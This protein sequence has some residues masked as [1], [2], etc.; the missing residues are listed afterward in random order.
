MN[1]P[2]RPAPSHGKLPLRGLLRRP[3]LL[4]LFAGVA[5][6]PFC[7]DWVWDLDTAGRWSVEAQLDAYYSS[8]GF[9]GPLSSSPPPELDLGVSGEKNIYGFLA[10]NF[11]V[12][13]FWLLEGSVNPMP[14][15]GLYLKSQQRPFYDASDVIH[16]L[17]LVQATTA[18]FPEPGAA[19]FFLG[20]V[21]K[22]TSAGQTVGRGYSG[23]VVSWA[24]WHILDN[25][26]IP[27]HW[28]E[29]EMKLKGTSVS[30]LQDLSWSFALGTKLHSNS[31]I[32]NALY[33]SLIRD[34]AD[35]DYDGW[36]LFRNSFFQYRVDLDM[37]KLS[38][39]REYWDE[40]AIRYMLIFGKKWPRKSG[41]MIGVDLGIL[42]Q[43]GS[44]YGGE[45]SQKVESEWNVLIRPRIEF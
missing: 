38:E 27:D 35:R 1:P 23:L 44:G 19:T 18:G 16:G 34:R 29:S 28:C 40:V 17:N 22:M 20:N 4:L 10:E 8:V 21:V 41:K 33:L 43:I 9:V 11:L 5:A 30:D 6:N 25:S 37:A 39:L 31:D 42:R 15:L 24:P 32:A 14:V 26:V 7:A 13:H 12:P 2:T 3:L 36:G 45:L